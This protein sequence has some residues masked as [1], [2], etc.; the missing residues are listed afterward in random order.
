MAEVWLRTNRRAILWGM[1]PPAA[2]VLVGVWLAIQDDLTASY[3]HLGGWRRVLGALLMVVG[4]S[5]V[6]ALAWQ[7]RRPRLAYANGHLEV[8]LRRGEPVRVPVEVIECFLIGQAASHLPSQGRKL[9]TTTVLIRLCPQ[10]AEWVSGQV[11]ARLGQ[12]RDSHFIIRGTWCE[13]LNV[14]VIRRLNARLGQVQR[15]RRGG[16]AHD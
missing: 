3:V 12:W 2:L 7:L 15:A 10:A 8:F 6:V 11:D 13:P 1:L 5:A 9:K 14:D 4:G 16:V